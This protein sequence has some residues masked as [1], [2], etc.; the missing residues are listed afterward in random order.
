MLVELASH[1]GALRLLSH[2][3]AG[4]SQLGSVSLLSTA[5]GASS[6]GDISFA[7]SFLSS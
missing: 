2:S 1:D 4:G 6:E 3:H 7:E 5:E